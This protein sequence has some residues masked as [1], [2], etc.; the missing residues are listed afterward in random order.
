MNNENGAR[1][2]ETEQTKQQLEG[3]GMID[4]VPLVFHGVQLWHHMHVEVEVERKPED[5]GV[6]SLS[7]CD[8]Q[9]LL[10][11]FNLF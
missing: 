4:S 10:F 8:S 6:K 7:F 1:R 5:C 11:D 9:R 2:V 3:I